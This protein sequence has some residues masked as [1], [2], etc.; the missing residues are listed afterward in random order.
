MPLH[1]LRSQS[2]HLDLVL[3]LTT[4]AFLRSFRRFVARRGLPKKVVSDNG[5]T[6]K[7]A[8]RIIKDVMNSCEM[9]K[10]F[11]GNHVEWTR[12][13]WWGGVFERMVGLMKK[14]LMKIVGQAVLTQD[15]LLTTITG[16]EA[17]LNSR[18]ISYIS[19][20]NNEEPL[21]PSHLIIGRRIFNLPN[22]TESSNDAEF[23]TKL[24]T[25]QLSQRG[26]SRLSW[27]TSGDDGG[28]S[29]C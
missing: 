10:Y 18:P 2:C 28:W 15:E 13:P 20:D 17:I 9:Q 8:G 14:C 27:T 19:T 12:A 21:T 24:S 7:V 5:K 29:I 6:F 16:V 25:E 4:E 23:N 11:S 22:I 1:L 26:I 3:D